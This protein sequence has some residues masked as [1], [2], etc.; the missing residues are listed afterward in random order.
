[1]CQIPGSFRQAMAN[2]DSTIMNATYA[3][4]TEG[5]DEDPLFIT[6]EVGRINE[7]VQV[8][9]FAVKKETYDGMMGQLQDLLPPCDGGQQHRLE[10]TMVP[11][12]R[13]KWQALKGKPICYRMAYCRQCTGAWKGLK[14]PTEGLEYPR[15]RGELRIVDKAAY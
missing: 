11:V 14:V 1:V 10:V 13:T 6:P 3:Q 5:T 7:Q 15:I 9:A 8:P 2:M 4:I 12:K